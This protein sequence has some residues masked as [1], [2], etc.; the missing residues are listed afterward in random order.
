M[1][2][3]DPSELDL[4]PLTPICFYALYASLLC[5]VAL[6]QCHVRMSLLKQVMHLAELIIFITSL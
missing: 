4:W 3:E 6:A 2:K 1:P 5:F